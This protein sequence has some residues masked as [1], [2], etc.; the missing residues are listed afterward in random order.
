MKNNKSKYKATCC[1]KVDLLYLMQECIADNSQL[2][3]FLSM[4]K[5]MKPVHWG[6]IFY[7]DKKG[8]RKH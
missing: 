6:Y 2:V 5:Y 7:I 4:N 1:Y 8:N 3:D